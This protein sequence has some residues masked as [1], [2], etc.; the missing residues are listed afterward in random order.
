MV[1]AAKNFRMPCSPS[2]STWPPT[3]RAAR[4]SCAGWQW[5]DFDRDAG[6]LNFQRQFVALKGGQRIGPLKSPTG[7][8]DGVRTCHV[9]ADTISALDWMR[10]HQK[11]ELHREIAGWL[12]SYDGGSTPLRAK[13]LGVAITAMGRK[14]GL[15]V[16][17]HS[18]RRTAATEL[19]ASGVDAATAS[20]RQG[21]TP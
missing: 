21:H 4:R 17:P 18:F 1:K 15:K 19:A 16:T 20:R 14:C 5:D 3:R 12:L 2:P 7:A 10:A 8:V 6:K 9:S 13:A 11:T